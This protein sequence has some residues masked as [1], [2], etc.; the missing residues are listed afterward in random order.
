MNRKDQRVK[1]A[2]DYINSDVVPAMNMHMA[3]GDFLRGAEWADE[4]PNWRDAPREFPPKIEG[5][6]YSK[7]VIIL[8][9]WGDHPEHVTTMHFGCYD[10]S[11]NE[12]HSSDGT[13]RK[14]K[15][16]IDIKKPGEK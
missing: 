16:W 12:W 8:V 4:N 1:A 13:V 6:M 3:F 14:V 9:H 11:T 15:Y 5:R 7:D 10:Y 2:T